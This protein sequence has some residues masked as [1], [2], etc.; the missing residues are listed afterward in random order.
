MI[1]IILESMAHSPSPRSYVRNFENAVTAT[2]GDVW[3]ELISQEIFE[4]IMLEVQSRIQNQIAVSREV[5]NL[6]KVRS[7]TDLAAAA[8]LFPVLQ[9]QW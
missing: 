9:S 6:V 7:A 2:H 1:Q 3:M 4:E 8:K 5:R